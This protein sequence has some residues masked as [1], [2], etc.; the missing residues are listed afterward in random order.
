LLVY[1]VGAVLGLSAALPLASSVASRAAPE[2]SEVELT[3]LVLRLF[4][5]AQKHA[6]SYAAVPLALQL[7]LTPWLRLLWLRATDRRDAL[8]GHAAAAALSYAQALIVWAVCGVY[9]LALLLMAAGA[10]W[11]TNGWLAFTHD[12][13][14][15]QL[16]ALLAAAPF[17]LALLLHVPL[18][19]D[20]ANAALACG[21]A[22]SARSGLR[23]AWRPSFGKLLL[24]R[25]AFG[26]VSAC[27]FA[28]ALLT[29]RA[30][31]GFSTLG[32]LAS[33]LVTQ[34]AAL[35]CILLRSVWF[36]VLLA[37][38]RLPA[39]NPEQTS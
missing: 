29:P 25:A 31:L 13:R 30:F 12:E 27:I 39:S 9:A 14:V 17:L 19:C 1:G 6:M 26:I 38:S 22:T 35:L 16:S 23:L 21:V 36:A 15:M 4:G 37:A 5:H 10:W 11:L 18:L 34:L 32:T 7:V 3:L 28:A 8:A 33:V 20:F 2:A 24:S